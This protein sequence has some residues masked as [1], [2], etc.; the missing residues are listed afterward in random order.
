MNASSLSMTEILVLF[1]LFMVAPAMFVLIWAAATGSLKR[2]EQAR[3]LPLRHPETD[4]WDERER[5]AT[6]GGR[7]T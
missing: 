5:D 2:S 7:N 1:S 6:R 4:F 3:S